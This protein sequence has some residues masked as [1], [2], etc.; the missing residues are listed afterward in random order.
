MKCFRCWRVCF[1]TSKME[2]TKI[3][4]SGKTSSSEDRNIPSIDP[5]DHASSS[6]LLV[7]QSAQGLEKNPTN[8]LSEERSGHAS[9]NTAGSFPMDP[10]TVESTIEPGNRASSSLPG[11]FSASVF[12][13]LIPFRPGPSLAPRYASMMPPLRNVGSDVTY[14][15][16]INGVS[17]V[18]HYNPH[19][20]PDQFPYTTPATESDH[21]QQKSCSLGN[22]EVERSDE[23]SQQAS[24]S[25]SLEPSSSSK[26]PPQ[27]QNSSLSLT[28]TISIISAESNVE[29]ISPFSE[30]Q[31]ST[32]TA[33]TNSTISY[34]A[35]V[36]NNNPGTAVRQK[37][38]RT[39]SKS[40][41]VDRKT[42]PSPE[43]NRE[44]FDESEQSE[45]DS[46]GSSVSAISPQLK[47]SSG[48]C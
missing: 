36:T 18:L 34:Q 41:S 24:S 48:F 13:S 23:T 37:S 8:L 4:P 1:T 10:Q 45:R 38:F 21:T 27:S 35:T 43:K 7:S 19:M 44:V 5:S 14:I 17:R 20:P 16:V 39:N 29:V 28:S 46:T 2:K 47:H 15:E 30:G 12:P 33:A 3:K 26:L 11:L 6:S 22:Q 32:L 40:D 42:S 31:T 9:E 25:L